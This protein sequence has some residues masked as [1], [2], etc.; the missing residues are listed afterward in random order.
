MLGFMVEKLNSTP[1]GI[2]SAPRIAGNTGAPAC[3]GERLM[4]NC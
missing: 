4:L 1:A 2:V 3:V